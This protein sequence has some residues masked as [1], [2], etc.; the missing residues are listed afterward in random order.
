MDL[1]IVCCSKGRHSAMSTKHVVDIDA[2]IVPANEVELYQEYN[3]GIEIIAQPPEVNNIVK[4]RQFV[5][6]NWSQVF[7]IDDD[8]Q[9]VTKFFTNPDEH[10]KVDGKK[11]VKEIIMQ[12]AY[13]A[14]EM[15]AKMF[16]FTT[17]RHPLAYHPQSPFNLT[18]YLNASHC[19]FLEGHNLKYDLRIPEGEDHF[20]SLYNI[21]VNRYMLIDNRYGFMTAQNFK[22]NGG[23]SIDRNT[24]VMQD[25]TLLLRE[26][27]GEAIALKGVSQLKKNVREGERSLNLP[28]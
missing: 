11:H 16:G 17:Q 27:F 13:L 24:E 1:K 23:C 8:V 21:F 4:A 6:D 3:K 28:F 5:L 9:F 18:G 15:G 20:I 2:I 10:H 7:M 25:T 14:Q 19:G 12:D 26:L 22:S